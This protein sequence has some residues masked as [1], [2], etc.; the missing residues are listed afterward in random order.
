METFSALL[1]LCA[2]NSPVTREFPTQRPVTRIFYGFFY[3]R[4]NKRLSKKSWGWWFEMPSRSLWRHCDENSYTQ[5]IL[6]I[7]K[8]HGNSSQC[9]D[10]R[11]WIFEMCSVINCTSLWNFSAFVI[12][13]LR[14][15]PKLSRKMY[16]MKPVYND[17][18]IRY[19]SAFC[20]K[21][22]LVSKNKLVHS[23]FIKTL[24]WINHC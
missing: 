10:E 22:E 6:C 8:I 14:Y 24:Y 18:L 4:V 20:Q 9:M 13:S 17:H 23:V 21:A 12:A 2:G 15:C 7:M 11:Y 19:F 1:A 3:L 16:T 5:C